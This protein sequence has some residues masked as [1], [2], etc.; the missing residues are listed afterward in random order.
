MG[1]KENT[2]KSEKQKESVTT[3]EIIGKIWSFP[4]KAALESTNM[5]KT[6]CLPLHR[7][8]RLPLLGAVK[9]LFLG[10]TCS[11]VVEYWGVKQQRQNFCNLELLLAQSALI[12]CFVLQWNKF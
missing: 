11:K 7:T 6:R 1:L 8:E 4:E 9:E 10:F 3:E 5:L 2:G 12:L